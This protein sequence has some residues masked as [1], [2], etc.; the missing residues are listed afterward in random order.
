MKLKLIVISACM[1][2][3]LAGF[4]QSTDSTPTMNRC[5]VDTV[6]KYG[7]KISPTY[8]KAVCTELVILIIEKFYPL[9]KTDKNR[10]RIIINENVH[11]LLAKDSP[12][13]K[14]VYYALTKKGVGTP[15]DSLTQ[16]RPGDFVQFWTE[17]W[18]HCGI[19]KSV[20]CQA[21]IMELY[22]SFPSTDG[23]GIHRFRIPKHC[24]FVRLV[25]KM[26]QKKTA[27]TI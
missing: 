9:D 22:S 5:V 16:V 25:E 12:L 3:N 17:T 14:G 13:P 23:Y 15:V 8:K 4:A 2:M 27:D 11:D 21:N 18:G 20:D 24:Y 6:I 7:A 10:I 19:V 26:N 1:L